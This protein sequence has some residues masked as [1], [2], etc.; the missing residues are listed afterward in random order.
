MSAVLGVS[1]SDVSHTAEEIVLLLNELGD[2]RLDAITTDNGANFVAAV[3]ELLET[4]ICEEH[5]R[6]ACHTLQCPSRH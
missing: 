5:V 3:E 6:C 1:V 2:D 4:G